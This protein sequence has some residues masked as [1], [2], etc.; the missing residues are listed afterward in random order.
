VLKDTGYDKVYYLGAF[1]DWAE[2]SGGIEGSSRQV[3]ECV[4]KNGVLRPPKKRVPE[5]RA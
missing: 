3:G 5:C 4:I 1:K 2:H